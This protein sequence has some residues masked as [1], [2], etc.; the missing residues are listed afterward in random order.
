LILPQDFKKIAGVFDGYEEI[1]GAS[2][3]SFDYAVKNWNVVEKTEFYRA[4]PCKLKKCYLALRE[5]SESF[6]VMETQGDSNLPTP[7]IWSSISDA[8]NLQENMKLQ[9]S[10]IVFPS[11]TSFFE[12]LLEQEEEEQR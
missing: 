1:G 3:F 9:D 7:I 2:L 12:Y 10:P 4:S 11:F 8:H 5:E 6:V